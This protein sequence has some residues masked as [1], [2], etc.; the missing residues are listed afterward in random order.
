MLAALSQDYVEDSSN[1]RTDYSRNYIRRHILPGLREL[2]PQ[3]VRHMARLSWQ[4]WEQNEFI[5]THFD[6]IYEKEKVLS[7]E[8]VRV[9][10][11]FLAGCDSFAQ[12]EIIRRM[13]FDAGGKRR[14]LASIHVALVQ[15]LLGNRPGRRLDLPHGIRA[16]LEEEYLYLHCPDQTDRTEEADASSG[17]EAYAYRIDKEQLETDGKLVLRAGEEE[18]QFELISMEE[19]EK[20]KNDCVRYFNYG[21]I[22][23]E[24]FLRTR[25]QGDYF[26]IDHLGRKKLL[27]R[28]FIDQKIPAA[29]RDTVFLLAEGNHILWVTGGRISEAYKVTDETGQVL[30]ITIRK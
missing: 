19:Y 22:K 11:P 27:R 2:N 10:L 17:E 12:K 30:R 29:R 15:D 1:A 13:L 9:S 20:R 4:M 18:Y 8:G 3:A 25:R 21:R 26:V 6:E 5:R 16:V 28:Y 23:N 24:L 14:D 7:P